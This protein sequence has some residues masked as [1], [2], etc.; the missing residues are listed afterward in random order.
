LELN[1]R[2]KDA[3]TK[4]DAKDLQLKD[5]LDGLVGQVEAVESKFCA[6]LATTQGQVEAAL[7]S[8]LSNLR[9]DMQNEVAGL[10][11]ASQAHREATEAFQVEV[12]RDIETKIAA[13]ALEL[14]NRLEG[15][16]S[17]NDATAVQL[18]KRLKDVGSKSDA[19]DL[20]LK[21]W[22]DGLAGQVKAV[23]AKFCA[24][25]AASQGQVET[26]LSSVLSNL[27]QDMQKEVADLRMASQAHKEATEVFQ[28]KVLRDIETKID[29]TALELNNR[30]T[31]SETSCKVS[32][33]RLT[34]CLAIESAA[35]ETKN[36]AT[37]L[38]LYNRLDNIETKSDAAALQLKDRLDGLVGQVGAVESKFC[39]E[40]ATTQG[41]VEASLS[42][43]LSNLRQDMQK[44]VA[45]MRMA[46]QNRLDGRVGQV[47]EH[48]IKASESQK[49]LP[50]VYKPVAPC[51]GQFSPGSCSYVP[52]AQVL[53]LQAGQR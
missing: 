42:S 3:E 29:A 21:D 50:V 26:S 5:R 33:A 23:E 34:E 46:W 43:G 14:N 40:L 2:L 10:R 44:E 38:Q 45:D 35:L 39:A 20:Q 15:V 12:L 25:L 19:T 36:D 24:E 28:V 16:E 6:E 48:T 13:T 32:A 11:T 1:N 41:Q 9:Q 37:A 47:P 17:K 52:R 49:K 22:L 30:L 27:R 51:T 53:T 7:F 4:G 31:D 8:G 18:N